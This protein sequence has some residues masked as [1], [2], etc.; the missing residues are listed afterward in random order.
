MAEARKRKLRE[1]LKSSW[2]IP[3]RL[4]IF[5]LLFGGVILSEGS[6]VTPL[7]L[8]LLYSVVTLLFLF[9]IEVNIRLIKPWLLSAV[10]FLHLTVELAIEG[11]IIQ[12]SGHLTSQ[13]SI[14]FLLTIISASLAY[15]LAGT[16]LVATLASVV[17]TLATSLDPFLFGGTFADLG[18]LSKAF[19]SR[20]DIFYAVFLHVCTFYLI[21]F[22]SGFL[23]EK[24]RVKEGELFS[25]SKNLERARLDTDDILLNLHSGLL[26]IDNRGDIVYFNRTAESILGMKEKDVKGRSFMGVF[27]KTMPE[28][29]ERILSVLKL[30]QAGIRTELEITDKNG[31]TIPLGLT[32]SVLGDERVGIRGV[33]AVFQ[34][35]TAAKK[36]EDA[37][38]K[39]DRLA[40]VGELSARIAHEIR[41][42]LA[43]ISGSV[44]VL[45]SELQLAGEN[46]RLMELIVKESERL[47]RILSDFLS[48]ARMQPAVRVKVELISVL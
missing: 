27:N 22:I 36:L 42:P 9:L 44:E 26:T 4:S 21:A 7:R 25:T 6:G 20:D 32:T 34:D 38:M 11:S 40:V 46:Q 48:Y 3:L 39:A 17:F 2:F 24:L 30:S 12:C 28:F 1:E 5:L 43:S 45:K 19:S 15:R 8:F 18:R 41:N 10:I 23:V 47:S 37:L 33:I 29:A 16:L 13:Y 14:L 35:L 31:R